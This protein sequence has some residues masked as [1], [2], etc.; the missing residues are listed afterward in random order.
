MKKRA[1]IEDIAKVLD[2]NPTTVSRAFIRPD[3]VKPATREKIFDT[4]RKLK[5]SPNNIAKGLVGKNIKVIALISPK[6]DPHVFP[7]IRGVTAE[8][9]KRQ[10]AL[11]LFPSDYWDDEAELFLEVKKR[12]LVDGFLIHNVVYNKNITKQV[13]SIKKENVPFVFINKYRGSRK[14]PNVSVDNYD[15]VYK[16][17]KHL[18]ELGH[19][20]IGIIN[21]NMPSVDGHE[22]F[23]AYKKFLKKLNIKYDES[24]VGYG[25]FDGDTAYREMNR[26]LSGS[27]RPTA[28]FCCSDFMAINAIK[29][30]KENGLKVPEDI[31]VA[32]FDNIALSRYLKPNL[33]TLRSP[34]E[35]I[36]KESVRILIDRIEKPSRRIDE[37]VFDTELIIR[38]STDKVADERR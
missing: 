31:S 10:H 6:L 5:Y 3:V 21:G 2:I 13:Q 26:I 24:I 20:R 9:R 15:A 17:M 12:W 22:R 35:E 16:V 8:C 28:M 36:A 18:S 30:I 11:M 23:D 7:V 4:A 38:E 25:E 32:G 27:G 37:V 14:A 33:T 29:A 34:L 19:R 1:T